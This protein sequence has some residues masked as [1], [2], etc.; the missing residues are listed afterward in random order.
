MSLVIDGHLSH[1]LPHKTVDF[2][3]ITKCNLKTLEKRLKNKGYSSKKVRENLDCEIF[4]TSLNEATE[5]GHKH[6]IPSDTSSES[7]SELAIKIRE[8]TCP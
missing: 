2:C 7:P 3:I 6:I 5:L 8:M 1:F 4:D